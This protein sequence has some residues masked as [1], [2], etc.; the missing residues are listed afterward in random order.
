[1]GLKKKGEQGPPPGTLLSFLTRRRKE[2]VYYT[3][4]RPQYCKEAYNL[5][6]LSPFGLAL[7]RGWPAR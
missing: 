1:M 7:T 6:L 2:C 4:G 3:M 5:D